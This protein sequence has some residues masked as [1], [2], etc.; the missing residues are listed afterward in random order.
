MKARFAR[1]AETRLRIIR[2]AADLFHKQGVRGTSPDEIIE[3]S[4]TGKGQFYHY[5]KS[6]EG[7]VHEVLQAYLEAITTGSA[8]LNYE[9]ESWKD[10]ERWFRAQIELQKSFQM[11]RG[12]PFGTV[13]NEV[14]EN[15]ELTR[16]DLSLIFEVVKNKLA[17]FFIKEKAK[18]RLSKRANEERMADFCIATIQGAMLMGKIRRSSH[19][20]E[21]TAREALAHLKGYVVTPKH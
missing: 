11:T 14:N 3:V 10:L 2:A 15:D 4:R 21:T 5:F 9:I 17:A 19:P 20:A 16:Q 6:K 12:C 7:L 18:G 1:G 8:P 13:G